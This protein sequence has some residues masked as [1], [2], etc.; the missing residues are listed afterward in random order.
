MAGN[1]HSQ[2]A[3]LTS[4]ERLR[5]LLRRAQAYIYAGPPRNPDHDRESSL[6]ADI[7]AELDNNN[8]HETCEPLG[9]NPT[10]TMDEAL[11]L[12][13]DAHELTKGTP[14]YLRFSIF[15]LAF[16]PGARGT[17]PTQK[18]GEPHKRVWTGPGHLEETGYIDPPAQGK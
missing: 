6:S 7:R 1:E 12:I 14:L 17:R 9:L 3:A 10:P 4:N 5:I 18:A 2:P 8:T 16:P 15:R 11:G 13:V